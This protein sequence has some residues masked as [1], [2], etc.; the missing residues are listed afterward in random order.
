[1]ASLKTNE[2]SSK[3]LQLTSHTATLLLV[4]GDV[5][6]LGGV[7]KDLVAVPVGEG[8]AAKVKKRMDVN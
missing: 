7:V 1:M 4:V 8:A 6:D 3:K 5:E 2:T